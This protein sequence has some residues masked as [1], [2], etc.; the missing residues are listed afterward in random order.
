[1]S[2]PPWPWPPPAAAG[3]F[4]GMSVI[5][6]SVV[7]TIAAIYAA[8]WRAERVTLRASTIPFLNMSPYSLR[9]AS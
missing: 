6:V 4:S 7:R 3:C 5:S 9:R 1:M 2:P 8:F